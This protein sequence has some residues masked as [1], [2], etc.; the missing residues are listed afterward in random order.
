MRHG[1]EHCM[2]LLR[3][4]IWIGAVVAVGISIGLIASNLQRAGFSPLIINSLLLGSILGIAAIAASRYL[5]FENRRIL[6]FGTVFAALA[7]VFSQHYALYM[8]Y[9]TDFEENLT[10]K[11]E[12]ALFREVPVDF[13]AYMR[14]ESAD[15]HAWLW[16][17]DGAIITATA[18]GIVTWMQPR[19]GVGNME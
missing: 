13:V 1:N 17:I 14:Q 16:L 2:Q 6:L 19:S 5:C 4:G 12:L 11:P 9:V 15:G 8:A 7:L 18:A 10:E 3:L